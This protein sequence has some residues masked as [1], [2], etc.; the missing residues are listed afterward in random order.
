ME[1]LRI[2]TK[3]IRSQKRI[4][5]RDLNGTGKL[6][7]PSGVALERTSKEVTM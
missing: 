4:R 7:K 3:I 6:M 1:K 5:D 2:P